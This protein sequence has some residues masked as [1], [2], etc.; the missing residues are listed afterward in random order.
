M[1]G[2]AWA[3]VVAVAG[4]LAVSGCSADV[5]GA[6]SGYEEQCAAA[7]HEYGDRLVEEAAALVDAL[8]GSTEG[9]FWCD[10]SAGPPGSV[11][12]ELE[13]VGDLADLEDR[14]ESAGWTL[15]SRVAGSA[16]NGLGA[17]TQELEFT[18][19]VDPGI[20]LGLVWA[21]PGVRPEGWISRTG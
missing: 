16:E 20:R 6:W 11:D 21:A 4:G 19:D 9:E 1:R 10:D 12:V 18:Q 8:G 3:G 14:V 5:A 13:V 15:T 2:R 17:G 7:Q